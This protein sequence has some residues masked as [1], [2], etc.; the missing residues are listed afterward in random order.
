MDIPSVEK[1]M[2]GWS[3]SSLIIGSMISSTTLTWI[4]SD[5]ILESGFRPHSTRQ[6]W[7]IR[8]DLHP[9]IY[10]NLAIFLINVESWTS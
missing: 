1:N 2:Y 6:N 8:W 5:T 10:Y 7:L 4:K 9:L 3:A